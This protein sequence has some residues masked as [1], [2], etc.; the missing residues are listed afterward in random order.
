MYKNI[1]LIGRGSADGERSPFT[2]GKVCIA[3]PMSY[4][5]RGGV[6][7]DGLSTRKPLPD[8]FDDAESISSGSVDVFT[9]PTLGRLDIMDI[10]SVAASKSQSRALK[11]GVDEKN[12][13]ESD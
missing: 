9:D 4:Y 2:G 13:S 6:D 12:A 1:K 10:A 7:L 11:R 5:V 3:R 8:A